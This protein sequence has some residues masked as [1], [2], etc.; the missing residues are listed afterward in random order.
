MKYSIALT[1]YLNTRPFFYHPL[2]GDFHMLAISPRESVQALAEGRAIAGIVPV[3]GLKQLEDFAE[4]LGDFGIA[5]EGPVR[6]VLFFSRRPFAAF[7]RDCTVSLTSESLTSVQLLS[8]LFLYRLGPENLPGVIADAA[9]SDGQLLIGDQALSRYYRGTDR[10]VTDLSD[11]WT[12]YHGCPFV[13]ARW[14]IHREADADVREQ[15][16]EWLHSYL[17]R[18]DHLK[19]VTAESECARYS[20][21]AREIVFY[22]QGIKTRIGQKECYGQQLYLDEIAKYKPEWLPS[23]I[24]GGKRHVAGF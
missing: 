5:S 6:S 18:E 14:V 20:M 12:R 4:P 17:L 7:S 1:P 23:C 24:K 22:L 8:L 9:D 13:F 19:Q 16:C 10:Y 3:A 11:E 15:L 2:P 21:T